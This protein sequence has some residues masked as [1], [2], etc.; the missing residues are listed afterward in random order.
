M[1]PELLYFHDPMCS[2][3]WAF[4]PVF[5]A[6]Q[7]QLPAGLTIRRVV[8]G[9]APDNDQPMSEEMRA[10]LQGTWRTIQETVP[11]TRFNFAFWK[12]CTPR[13][14]TYNA[15]RAV[16]A[17]TRLS[18]EHEDLMTEAIQHA[19]Y[20]EARNPS[21]IATLIILAGVIGLDRKRF[22][23]E[24]EG[25]TVEAQL[26]EELAFSRSAPIQGFPGLVARSKS[27]LHQVETDYR[28]P[29]PMRRQIEAILKGD[30]T[31]G[32]KLSQ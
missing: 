4:R 28:D 16:L 24:I 3:C 12:K 17:A 31:D 25:P 7:A 22:T 14:S 18:P 32:R 26:R 19:Y 11:G 8:G 2:W 30:T 1:T 9:L 27:G 5:K 10:R 21:D 20:L 6:L 23:A 13:R 15:C 29:E